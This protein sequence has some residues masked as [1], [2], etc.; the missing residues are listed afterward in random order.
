ML[1]ERSKPLA[2]VTC[3]IA[4]RFAIPSNVNQRLGAMRMR[5]HASSKRSSSISQ[6]SN[7][8]MS[9]P[10]VHFF[11]A[12]SSAICADRI[13]HRLMIETSPKHW[14]LPRRSSSLP[15]RVQEQEPEAMKYIG[16]PVSPRRVMNV[17]LW[18]TL[19][20]RRSAK[21]RMHVSSTVLAW[22]AMHAL[23]ARIRCSR[24]PSCQR[25]ARGPEA[26]FRSFVSS[27]VITAEAN[28]LS[29]ALS[30]F[31]KTF[32][33]SLSMMQKQPSLNNFRSLPRGQRRGAP[34]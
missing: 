22:N 26:V 12:S 19:G 6:R 18:N 31:V 25:E 29:I 5:G 9:A 13:L 10:R 20:R 1:V 17:P 33:G 30:S 16:S 3:F 14:P 8:C 7:A 11:R 24:P 4:R 32:L 28:T 2:G 23:S 21:R 34:A 27:L 15:K